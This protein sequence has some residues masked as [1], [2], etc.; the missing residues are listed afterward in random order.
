MTMESNSNNLDSTY[1]IP[2]HPLDDS[3]SGD[4][5]PIDQDRN[6]SLPSND[7]DVDLLDEDSENSTIPL[8]GG[9]D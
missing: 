1:A 4:I 6:L 5:S 3:S 9:I 2:A 7:P 8:P